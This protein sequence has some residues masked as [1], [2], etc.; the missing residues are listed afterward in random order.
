MT[1]NLILG[2]IL[3]RFGPNLVQTFSF[4]GFTFYQVLYTVA[5]YHCMRFQGKLINQTWE[6]SKNP[7]FTPN[8]GPFCSNLDPQKISVDFI[9][10]MLHIIASYHCM[11]FQGNLMNQTWENYK[12][13]SFRCVFGPFDPNL[14][15]WNFVV[16]FT[17]TKY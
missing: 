2:L 11:Q 7:S 17:S 5:S 3:A 8:F 9:S 12:K 10:L 16:D 14:D 13:P 15:T 6:N 1:K 4:E